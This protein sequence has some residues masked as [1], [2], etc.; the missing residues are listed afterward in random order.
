MKFET[1]V[2]TLEYCKLKGAYGVEFSHFDLSGAN[3]RYANLRY[4]NLR[5]ANLGGAD[6]SGA[7]LRGANLR[8]AN[9]GGANLRGANLRGA[10]LG[11]A[12]LGGANLSGADLG[13]ANLIDANLSGANLRGATGNNREIFTL[14]TGK[15]IVNFV[16][17]TDVIHIGC[18]NH[19]LQEWENFTDD[20]IQEMDDGALKFW[21][22][23]KPTIFSWIN[24]IKIQNK[25]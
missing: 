22:V 10:N 13:G 19:T 23:W 4:A 12:D 7:N 15:Y 25:D 3:L 20:E 24:A 9:L 21:S 6:L 17:S 5:Y 2:E 18:Q 16:K 14:Q 1:L 11:G 8:G